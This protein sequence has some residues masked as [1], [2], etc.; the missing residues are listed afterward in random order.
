M[1]IGEDFREETE[2]FE[3]EMRQLPNTLGEASDEFKA[4]YWNWW[5][6]NPQIRM[7]FAQYTAD[8]SHIYFFNTVWKK[9]NEQ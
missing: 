4:A 2:K 9:R 7:K 8:M 5:D 3:E 1:I 6:S